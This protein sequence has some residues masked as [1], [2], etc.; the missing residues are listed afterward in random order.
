MGGGGGGG[1]RRRAAV[2]AGRPCAA[3]STRGQDSA[4]LCVLGA[5]RTGGLAGRGGD[6]RYGPV[7]RRDLS[8]TALGGW[9]EGGGQGWRWRR[10][11]D[12]RWG[13]R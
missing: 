13:G 10:G 12:G 4:V 6:A 2:S 5:G 8:L 3:A 11:R 1:R 7:Q 9:R